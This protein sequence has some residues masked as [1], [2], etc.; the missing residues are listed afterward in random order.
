MMCQ[1]PYRQ[2]LYRLLVL[3]N[4]Q[5]TSRSLF[6]GFT[7]LEILIVT[8]IVGILAAIAIP[9]YV[10]T[11]DKARYGEAKSQMG[12]LAKELLAFRMEKGNFPADT[13]RNIRPSGIECF[14]TQSSGKVPFDSMY[15]YDLTSVS[16]GNCYVQI[17]FLGKN[18]SKETPNHTVLY[19]TPG[20]YEYSQ[21]QANSDDL[22][23]SLGTNPLGA[24]C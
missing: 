11:I 19:P 17:V 21:I 7:L 13:S 5:L 23:Y 15:D 20:I 24:G 1:S 6:S 18:N 9:S 3:E 12:C 22:I 8:I 2:L 16:P 10:A 4:K 14:Y